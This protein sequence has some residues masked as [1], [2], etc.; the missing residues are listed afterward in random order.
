[1]EVKAVAKFIRVQPRKVRR[2]AREV[3][4]KSAQRSAEILRFHPSKSANYLRRVILSAVANAQENHGADPSSLRISEIQIG[5]GPTIKRIKA[6]AQG[7]ANRILKRTSHISV[8]VDEMD[9]KADVKPHG[10]KPKARPSFDQPKSKKKAEAKV[11][12]VVEEEAT[13]DQVESAVEDTEEV[14][15]EEVTEEAS[16]DS[17]DGDEK[18]AE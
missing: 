4:G 18:A 3:R 13:E 15:T 2:I 5:E 9:P 8:T 6:R 1:M 12:D 7:R 10:T 11:E 14:Q 17:T 16:A